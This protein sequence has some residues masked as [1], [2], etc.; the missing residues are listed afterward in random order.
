[1]GYFYLWEGG[2]DCHQCHI[3]TKRSWTQRPWAA[4]AEAGIFYSDDLGRRWTA[5]GMGGTLVFDRIFMPHEGT[6]K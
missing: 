2:Y 4:T 1:M 3:F 6:Q 5:A